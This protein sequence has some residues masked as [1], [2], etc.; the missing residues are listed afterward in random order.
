MATEARDDPKMSEAETNA[1]V[2]VLVTGMLVE[3]TIDVFIWSWRF[4]PTL[5][6][7]VRTGM[8]FCLRIL[9]IVSTQGIQ[10]RRGVLT[11]DS[12]PREFQYS[13]RP[14]SAGSQDSLFP[15]AN[16]LLLFILS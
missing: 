9:P 16:E 8:P 10:D 6:R 1:T 11:F 4:S 2:L 14:Q 5:G 13:R 7:L 12:R 3:T 15:R